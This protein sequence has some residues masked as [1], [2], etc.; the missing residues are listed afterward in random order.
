MKSRVEKLVFQFE[1]VFR[2]TPYYGDSVSN[3]L[4]QITFES[5]NNSVNNGH[6]IAQILQHMLAWRILA[7]EH[8]KG[9]VDYDIELGSNVDWPDI[10]M[11]TP[12]QWKSLNEAFANS[13]EVLI[14]LLGEKTDDW[15]NSKMPKKE[16]SYN[17]MLKGILQHDIYHSGQINLLKS[18]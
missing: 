9:N 15:L 13:N 6:S 10:K 4:D 7:I 2:G 11:N 14:E 12:L 16:F 5:A 3:I 1:N 17:F 8:L 18:V